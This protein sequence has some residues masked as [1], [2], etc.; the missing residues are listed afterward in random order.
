M[1]AL[2]EF[3]PSTL[4]SSLLAAL[5]TWVALLAWTPFA[6][7]PAGFMVPLFGACALVAVSG[8]LLRSARLPALVVLL[9]QVVLVLL[10]LQHRFGA[11]EAIAGVIPTPDSV[12]AVVDAVRASAAVSQAYAAICVTL[13][14]FDLRIRKEG[15]DLEMAARQHSRNPQEL[16]LT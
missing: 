16:E 1:S 8:M 3:R 2:S 12:R 7:N 14:Y 5:T 11:H 15:F 6:E 10:W 9:A 4:L 13:L